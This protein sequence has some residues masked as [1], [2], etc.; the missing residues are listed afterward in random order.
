[1]SPPN[2]T[3]MTMTTALVRPQTPVKLGSP[4]LTCWSSA[5]HSARLGWSARYCD[6]KNGGAAGHYHS[7]S[8]QSPK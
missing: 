4:A 7:H 2:L 3:G 5:P 6:R 8:G 1:M